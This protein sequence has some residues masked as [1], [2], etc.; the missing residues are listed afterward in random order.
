[1]GSLVDQD[2]AAF[3]TPGSTPCA[4]LVVA[5]RTP[6]GVDHPLRAAD[7]AQLTAGNDLLDLLVQLVGALVEHDAE[8]N[9]G[10]SLSAGDHLLN[11]LA[12][13]AGGLLA[14]NVHAMLHSVDGD[15]VVQVVRNSGDDGINSA[16]GDHILPIL[17]EGHI[18]VLLLAHLLLLGI[19]ITQ[20]AQCAVVGARCADH[21]GERSGSVGQEA[22]IAAALST[23][24]DQAITNL[25]FSL[26]HLNLLLFFCYVRILPE[27]RTVRDTVRRNLQHRFCT[28]SHG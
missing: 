17:E 13:D 16:A 26:F 9:F 1:M 5:V 25:S 23:D 14:Q 28:C 22:S 15:L 24:T 4:L 8:G 21:A 18:G 10:M 3:A 20:S 12:A 11:I 27:Y 6:P 2:T 19:D 7:L